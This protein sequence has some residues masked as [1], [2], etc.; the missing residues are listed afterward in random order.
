[1]GQTRGDQDSGWG[2]GQGAWCR[3]REAP[4]S[5]LLFQPKSGRK[6]GEQACELPTLTTLAATAIARS[7]AAKLAVGGK[8][9]LAVTFSYSI[10]PR[11]G[12]RPEA[13]A[14]TTRLYRVRGSLPPPGVITETILSLPLSPLLTKFLDGNHESIIKEWILCLL[15]KCLSSE[16]LAQIDA[17]AFAQVICNTHLFH[18]D[19]FVS[20]FGNTFTGTLER[21]F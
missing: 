5:L 11:R 18:F 14:R 17:I 1:M 2:L 15:P 12:T 3:D 21:S 19:H 16:R 13:E 4:A 6:M 7:L 8:S 10:G 20:F 9:S